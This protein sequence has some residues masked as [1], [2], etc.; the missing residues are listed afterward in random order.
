MRYGDGY[1]YSMYLAQYL[2]N[3][4]YVI[5]VNLLGNLIINFDYSFTN[6]LAT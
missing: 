2:N 6:Q 5:G 4:K 3:I 1:E